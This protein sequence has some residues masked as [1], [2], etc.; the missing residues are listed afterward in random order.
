MEWIVPGFSYSTSDHTNHKAIAPL[1]QYS[2]K[3]VWL[4]NTK[5]S[6]KV[7]VFGSVFFFLFQ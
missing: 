7:T 3:Y 6:S 4:Q 5:N 2:E 1:D